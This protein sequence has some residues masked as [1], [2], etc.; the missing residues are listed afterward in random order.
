MYLGL[1]FLIT[2][3]LKPLLI[4]V[5]IGLPGGAHEYD[6]TH[7]VHEGRTSDVF[8]RIEALSRGAY[9]RSFKDY[10]LALPFIGPLKAVKLWMDGQGSFPDEFHPALRLEDKWVQ[11]GLLSPRVPM[12]LTVL[13]SG[14]RSGDAAAFMSGRDKAVLKRRTGR[15]GRGL[16]IVDSLAALERLTPPFS[17]PLLLQE[18]VESRVEGMA[19]SVRAVAFAGRFLCM[20]ANLADRAFSNHG[21]LAF[22]LPGYRFGLEE[23]P[24][25]TVAFDE[26]S[27]E[28]TIWFGPDGSCDPPHLRHN[29]NEE[30]V[31]KAGLVLPEPAHRAIR[32]AAVKV[33]R[34][35]EA[36]EPEALPPAWF[37]S[38][39]RPRY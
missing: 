24:R 37:E 19:L 17:P 35:Y 28:A 1:D 25:D 7:R 15:G 11:Y 39:S 3:D 10:L 20:Y 9:G 30:T 13:F 34:L 32:D 18:Y 16:V 2:P 26:R 12:P 27:W 8:N 14:E 4:E 23:R 21:T 22:V 33:E 6:L 36:L 5:N 29:L 31:L 38:I